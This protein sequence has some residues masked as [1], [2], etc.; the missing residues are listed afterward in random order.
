MIGSRASQNAIVNQI[1][2]N[3]SG[4]GQ[5]KTRAKSESN[6]K[7]Q[8]GQAISSKNHSIKSEQNMRSIAK[9]YTSFVKENFE[10]KISKNLNNESMEKFIS[11]KIEEGIALSSINTY[12][13]ALAKIS[14]NLNEL[15][16]NT[17]SRES[18]TEYRNELK[19]EFGSLQSI[20]ENRA[21]DNAQQIVDSMNMNTPYGLSAELQ[22][23][24]GLRSDDALNISDKITIN[25][26][27]T[28]SIQG[29]KGGIS[30]TTKELPSELIDRVSRAIEQGYSVSYSEYRDT[31]KGEVERVSQKW[32]G[33][34]GLRYNYAQSEYQSGV[35]KEEIS[36]SMGHSR[37]SITDHYLK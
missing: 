14:D 3:S 26:N 11:H 32:N 23:S 24:A 9:Q 19:A 35:S 36:L 10:G 21:Y 1:M 6:I 28:L 13:S 18:I 27:Y 30:Y 7:G 15:G 17:T 31:L 37:E 5:S 8:N 4:I 34:H 20:H 12:I 16:I 33:T 29:S 2:K 22:V 25:Q